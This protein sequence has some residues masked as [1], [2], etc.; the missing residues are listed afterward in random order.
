VHA[1]RLTGPAAARQLWV[2]CD[3]GVF[4]SARAGRCNTFAARVTG[5]AA[6]EIG[7]AAAHPVSSQ[8]LAI[9]S[10]DN[11]SHVRAG[12]TVWDTLTDADAGGVAIHP[13][14]WHRV[15]AQY[16]DA[17]WYAQPTAGYRDPMQRGAGGP[18]NFATIGREARASLF[19]SGASS[20][21][22]TAPAGRIALGTNRVWVTDDLGGGTANS[23][24]VLPKPPG[25]APSDPRPGGGDP[26]PKRT[27]GVPP[28]SLGAVVTVRWASP[29]ELYALYER[30]LVHHDQTG[31]T[32]WT[33]TVLLPAPTVPGAPGASAATL[34]TDVAPV[35]GTSAY[36]L[37]TNGDATNS[38]V[39]TCWYCDRTAPGTF[40]ATGLRRKLDLPGTPPT[41]GPL[42]AAFAVV[43]DPGDTSVVYVGTATGVWR[44]HLGTDP[45]GAITHDWAPFVNGLPHATVQDLSIWSDGTR[46]LLRAAVQSRGVWEVDLVADEPPRTY[47]RVHEHDDR[48]VLPVP[49]PSPRRAPGSP[50]LPSTSSPD[51]VVRPAWP[52]TAPSTAPAGATAPAWQLGTGR[53]KAD[54]AP[55]YELW[56]FQTAFRWL[57]P[58][59]AA[60]GEWTDQFGDVVALHRANDPALADGR[61]VDRA[62][63]DAVVGGVRLDATG[64][65][66]STAT[67]PLAVYRPAW[68]HPAA[69][70]APATEVDVVELVRPPRVTA[71]VWQVYRERSTVE[72]L[73]HHRDTRPLAVDDAWV[74]LLWAT[75]P[76]PA[77]LLGLAVAD[78]PTYAA[79]VAAG[80]PPATPPAGWTPVAGSGGGFCS[81]LPV[82]LDARIPR[83]VPVDLDLSTV[84]PNN[85]VLLLAVV[86]SSTET[87]TRPAP[88]G[89]PAGVVD[90]VRGWP[91]AAARLL[92][93]VDR[94]V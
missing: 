45:S 48:R 84:P 63:W 23:W 75:D 55:P 19:Y 15:V 34:L 53:I 81:R 4:L 5:L 40:I 69:L 39:E 12:D 25:G 41:P 66:T 24:R 10:Q 90:L 46:R 22:T 54:N 1:L 16:T 67:D 33:T 93:V 13:T 17:A 68:Q 74:V 8:F 56:T 49:L 6:L 85:A 51:V 11:G 92:T 89:T 59:T 18:S 83:A 37:V 73:L 29:T 86:G 43:V 82:R 28:G 79:A 2:G 35:P 31:P 58:G 44:G 3:G 38:A 64:A 61:Y 36:Y 9:G 50:D 91:Y 20:V 62:M 77:T 94:P 57:Y 88:V 72:V 32:A 71:D 70:T 87:T 42:D 47:V 60:T 7:F 14:Q 65:V 76:S 21:R 30:G 80:S 26:V 78:V 52:W 27:V